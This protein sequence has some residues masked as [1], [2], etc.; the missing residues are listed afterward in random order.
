MQ[1]DHFLHSFSHEQDVMTS[2]WEAIPARLQKYLKEALDDGEMA[3]FEC[4]PDRIRF[5]V[6]FADAT[7][8]KFDWEE[9][10]GC[11]FR[12]TTPRGANKKVD[13]H[14]G[15]PEGFGASID[16]VECLAV[17]PVG[18]ASR[19]VEIARSRKRKS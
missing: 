11:T 7:V 18:I 15:D 1:D 19:I 3:S 12:V 16:W 8:V 2:R 9:A 5:A 13:Y 10:D 14:D 4:D 17:A 6:T